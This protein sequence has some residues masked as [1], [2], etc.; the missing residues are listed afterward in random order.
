MSDKQGVRAHQRAIGID[1]GHDPRIGAGLPQIAAGELQ[2]AYG[3]SEPDVGG[4]LAAVKPRAD[5]DG[6]GGVDRHHGARQ[7][8]IE[9]AIDRRA[10][11]CRHVRAH[12]FDEGADRAAVLADQVHIGFPE[13]R[14][15][16]I[17][18][19]EVV[20]AHLIPV[21]AGPVDPA[22]ANL[23]KRGA[24][25]DV[26]A[27]HLARDRARG[28]R[29]AVLAQLALDRLVGM[30]AAPIRPVLLLALPER[31]ATG[32][33]SAQ[34]SAEGESCLEALRARLPS[35]LQGIDIEAFPFG[36]AS[37]AV[38]LRRSPFRLQ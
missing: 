13:L 30:S 2:F 22:F 31:Y 34:L 20:L 21:P 1:R 9:L 6:L 35:A 28:A 12:D 11:A 25:P 27:Q 32:P 24:D 37:G 33:L 18:A 19:E 29:V 5:L 16:G 3:L 10:P 38:A 26:F 15:L 23:H 8:R 14:G 36:R 17:R 4:D 7:V